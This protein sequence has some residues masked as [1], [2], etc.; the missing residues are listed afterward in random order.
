MLIIAHRL[1]TIIDSDRV[2][3][4]QDGY[5]REFDHPYKLLVKNEGDQEIT[6]ENGY[7][8]NML[9]ATGEETA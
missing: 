9:K 3:V 1:A 7:F 2:L 8:A 6:N 4:M 5:G